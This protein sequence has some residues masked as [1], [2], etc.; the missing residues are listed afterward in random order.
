MATLRDYIKAKNPLLLEKDRNL[1]TMNRAVIY[2]RS[3]SKRTFAQKLKDKEFKD[4]LIESLNRLFKIENFKKTFTEIGENQNVIA[5]SLPEEEDDDEVD[6]DDDIYFVFNAGGFTVYVLPTGLATDKETWMSFAKEDIP[7]FEQAER[8]L[9]QESKRIEKK[10]KKQPEKEESLISLFTTNAEKKMFSKN[11]RDELK[12]IDSDK[13]HFG[14]FKSK[15]RGEI[16]SFK[17]RRRKE[18][19][20]VVITRVKTNKE[21][22]PRGKF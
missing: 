8:M 12:K 20:H 15:A 4:T 21:Y 6:V 17:I 7:V 3:M 9:S 16:E 19:N 1:Y 13:N 5:I 14:I 2:T 11:V 18:D 22:F 10:M